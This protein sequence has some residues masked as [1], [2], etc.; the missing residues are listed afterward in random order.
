MF[1]ILRAKMESLEQ[2]TAWPRHFCFPL[3]LH[4]NMFVIDSTKRPFLLGEE[5]GWSG[6]DGGCVC[7]RARAEK[8]QAKEGG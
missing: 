4:A 2:N 1:S 5:E 8:G 3:L 6:E 7:G